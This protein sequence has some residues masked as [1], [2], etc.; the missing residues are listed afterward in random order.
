MEY[1]RKGILSLK[2][3]SQM[4]LRKVSRAE[5]FTR[6]QITRVL[7]PLTVQAYKNVEEER[8]R[9]QA[10]DSPHGDPWHVSFHASQF[11]GDDPQACPRQSLYRMMDFPASEP[12]SRRSRVVM[13]IGKWMETNLVRTWEEDG[14][15]LTASPDAEVQTGFAF[16]DVWFTGSVDAIIKP[17]N[18][19]KPLPVEVKTKDRDTIDA[20][21]LG[22]RGPDPA[23]VSQLK[24]QL[25]LTALSQDGPGNPWPGL[26]R[27]THGYIYYLSRGDKI[28]EREIVTAEFRVDLDMDFFEMGVER[29]KQW[30]AWFEEGFLPELDPGKRSSKFG[31]P[32][33]W[34]WS[35]PPC[36]WCDFKKTC[37]LDFREGNTDLLES[38][39]VERAKLVRENYDPQAARQRVFDRWKGLHGG[40]EMNNVEDDDSVAA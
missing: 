4:S 3:R 6:L 38:A 35:Y 16:P 33:G 14:I 20:M 21:L 15:L 40:V 5:F 29:L 24:V 13:G 22:A 17:H 11:P 9:N 7:D 30:R 18:W 19:N 27:V 8:W 25:A 34:K 2:L 39:G 12:F 26:D 1:D 23:H 31:H 36:A 37:Q 32:N 10:D 28:G